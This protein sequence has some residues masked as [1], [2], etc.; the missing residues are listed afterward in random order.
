MIETKLQ[1]YPSFPF[2]FKDNGLAGLF[3]VVWALLKP[4]QIQQEIRRWFCDGLGVIPSKKVLLAQS[5]SS[6]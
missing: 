5:Q 3:P 2:C 6:L 4:S 1:I